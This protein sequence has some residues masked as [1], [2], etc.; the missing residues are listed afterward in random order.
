M[1]K[2]NCAPG[3]TGDVN[4]CFKY[5]QLL[6]ILRYINERY[7]KN[8]S[9]DME[10]DEILDI[11]D[12]RIANCKNNYICWVKSNF[13]KEMYSYFNQQDNTDNLDNVNNIIMNT[14]RPIGPKDSLDWLNTTD[15]NRVMGQYELLYP[16]FLFLGATPCDFEEISDHIK[17]INFD[18]LLKNNKY[19]LGQVINLDKHYQSGS[20]WVGLYINLIDVKIYFF[21]STGHPPNELIKKFITKIVLYFNSI[22]KKYENFTEYNETRKN[23]LNKN[24]NLIKYYKDIRYNNIRHQFK[25]SECGVYSINFIIS[26]L[27]NKENF[28]EFTTNVISDD[29]IA[30]LRQ[31]IFNV[32]R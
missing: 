6:L 32:L 28:K 4:K 9:Y 25:N 10:Y 3:N 17:N 29:N 22:H 20:H 7:N 2:Y 11:I 30:E 16:Y 27:A 24:V 1:G 21:D 14:F 26:M 31:E 13:L 15:I 8:Y 18:E 19:I 12:K 5:E 23:I